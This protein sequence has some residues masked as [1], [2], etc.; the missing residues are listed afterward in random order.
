MADT[1]ATFRGIALLLFKWLLFAV[2]GIVA[3]A[4]VVWGALYLFQYFTHDRHAAKV[5]IT[6]H[7]PNQKGAVCADQ[8][9][10]PLFIGIINNSSKT[11]EQVRFS[12]EARRKGRSTNLATYKTYTD[13]K[14]RKPGEGFGGCWLAP[15]LPNVKDDPRELEWKASQVR[16]TFE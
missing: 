9:E 4:L 8:A 12:L 1:V 13:D 15:L 6:I 10:R 16:I 14:I 2:L 7:D 11:I 5:V 3:I